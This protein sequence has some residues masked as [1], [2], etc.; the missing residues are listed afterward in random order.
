VKAFPIRRSRW[1]LPFLAPLAAAHPTATVDAE[2]VSVCVGWAGRADI[3]VPLI[4]A[5]GRMDWPWWFG[6]GVGV[7]IVRGLV[8]F[9]GG[10]GLMALLELSEPVRVKTPL[11]WP[12][13]RIA[14]GVEDVEGF[15]AE[16]A[17]VRAGG[18]PEEG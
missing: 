4:A 3:P 13:S 16:I 11:S 6:V 1:A 8:A 14:I 9:S 7:R 18:R 15:I 10:P 12:A 2:C 5:A 17:R